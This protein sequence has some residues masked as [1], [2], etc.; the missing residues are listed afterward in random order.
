MAR[1]AA[2][3]P[4]GGAQGRA[5]YIDPDQVVGHP[6]QIGD[7]MAQ[8]TNPGIYVDE[9]S[10]KKREEAKQKL[11]DKYNLLPK[12]QKAK[13]KP[14]ENYRI[15]ERKEPGQAYKG[16]INPKLL[17]LMEAKEYKD[18]ISMLVSLE[19]KGYL[20]HFLDELQAYFEEVDIYD[21]IEL[22]QEGDGKGIAATVRRDWG[23]IWPDELEEKR[24]EGY[25]R[26]ISFWS[27]LGSSKVLD[28]VVS[29]VY[30]GIKLGKAGIGTH[31]VQDKLK[32]M[33]EEKRRDEIFKRLGQNE[34][35]R[36]YVKLAETDPET[37]AISGK[38]APFVLRLTVAVEK[39]LLDDN[40]DF[41][42]Q[43]NINFAGIVAIIVVGVLIFYRIVDNPFLPTEG[44][45]PS[46]AERF[47]ELEQSYVQEVTKEAVD[48][49]PAMQNGKD[50]DQEQRKQLA[51][52]LRYAPRMT[53]PALQNPADMPKPVTGWF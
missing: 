10:K 19:K 33:T 16:T 6:N 1:N 35:V 23:R 14:L 31:P 4:S 38:V 41:G 52:M 3:A 49:A 32:R 15:L 11:I 9:F 51:D 13:V 25:N 17:T 47:P 8:K 21:L 7:G 28:M 45:W 43:S 53:D 30:P 12:G 44:S 34:V 27:R 40:S 42:T 20:Q 18:M 2:G 22:D 37:Q 5:G 26:F 46:G 48:R 29:D 36:Q 50:L 24:M 39:K